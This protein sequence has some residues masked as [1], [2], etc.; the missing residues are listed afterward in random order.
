MWVWLQLGWGKK[1]GDL[2]QGWE[3]VSG[4]PVFCGAGEGMSQ[5]ARWATASRLEGQLQ[6]G[7]ETDCVA[8]CSCC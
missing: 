6:R 2:P 5:G 3:A 7:E 8:R 4:T 1:R